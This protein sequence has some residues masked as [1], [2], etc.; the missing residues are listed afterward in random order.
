MRCR[1]TNF[2]C[3]VA[4]Y[5]LLSA[6]VGCSPPVEKPPANNTVSSTEIGDES[7]KSDGDAGM[8]PDDSDSTANLEEPKI[9]LVGPQVVASV[10]E[11]SAEVDEPQLVEEPEVHP[12]ETPDVEVAVVEPATVPDEPVSSLN[13]N[14]PSSEL[15][16]GIPGTGPLTA[17]QV[18]GWL[19]QP[20]NHL[21]IDIVLP[22]G[23]DEG[24]GQLFIPPDNPLTK[25]KI[26]LGRQLYFDTRMSGDGSISCASCHHPDHGYTKPDQFGVGIDDQTGN[27]NSPV[28]YN[29]ILSQAQFWDGRAAT[30]EEQAKGPIANA[31]EHGTTHEQA[32]AD[33][34]D[35]EAYRLQFQRVFGPNSVNIDN[36]AKA[37]ASFERVI[38][39]GPSP[40]DYYKELLPFLEFDEDD[41]AELR[42]DSPEVYAKYEA[43]KSAAEQYAMSEPAIRGRALFFG[44][45]AGCTAC[46]VGANF[47][48]EK[49]HNLG[50]GMDQD[51]PDP[52]RFKESR[53]EKETGAFKTPT[54]RNV[55]LTGP[56]MHDGSQKTLKEVVEWYVKGGHANPHL[57]EK[58]K[59]LELSDQD[60][61]D[62]VE[63]MK[64]LTGEFP[65]VETGRLP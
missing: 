48:D 52:G 25:A 63:Y 42:E 29:R 17:D 31:I 32:V 47:T 46:H 28:S 61:Q 15:T 49:F 22:L 1:H 27:R 50:V 54:L 20:E 3:C 45:K 5:L 11:P 62:L 39:T 23:L 12:T 8:V 2:A 57:S 16:A 24:I 7:N 44:D 4:A 14:L 35:V 19:G 65:S 64:A 43:A 37:I 30:L 60:K 9:E 6:F 38:V 18:R 53:D 51:Q 10:E 58:I 33:I 41:L 55:T 40:N 56:Y 36:I 59:K 34:E 13:V 21:T 26:E